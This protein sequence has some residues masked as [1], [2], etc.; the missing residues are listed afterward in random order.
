MLITS[1]TLN[2]A[3]LLYDYRLISSG[4]VLFLQSVPKNIR[5]QIFLLH[6]RHSA[7]VGFTDPGGDKG[8]NHSSSVEKVCRNTSH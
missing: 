6:A 2:L 7:E 8:A 1:V 5:L 3:L 4:A